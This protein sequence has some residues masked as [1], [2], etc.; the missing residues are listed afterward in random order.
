MNLRFAITSPEELARELVHL[1]GC[2][3]WMELNL[4]GCDWC[5]GGGK[6]RARYIDSRI[7]AVK[8]QL[9]ESYVEAPLV[10]RECAYFD[11]VTDGLCEKCSAGE[12]D[13]LWAERPPSHHRRMT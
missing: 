1:E 12:T 5:C 6:E 4:S 7:E 13:Q 8:A 2:L 9:G 3:Q 10:C 11:A